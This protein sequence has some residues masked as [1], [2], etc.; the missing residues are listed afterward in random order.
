M[1]LVSLVFGLAAFALVVTV[2]G[3]FLTL[4]FFPSR[5]D[6]DGIERLAFSFVFSISFLPLLMLVENQLLSLPINYFTVLS[7]LLLLVIASLL[8]FLARTRK[9]AVPEPFCRAFPRVEPSE[10]VDI[11]PFM[12]K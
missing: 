10:A 2:P 3:Y 11:I 6:I 7:S 9:I 1:E 5:K 4:A 8:V 12:K